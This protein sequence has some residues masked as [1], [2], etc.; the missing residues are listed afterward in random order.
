M[1]LIRIWL[2]NIFKIMYISLYQ[3]NCF[4]SY[5]II[6]KILT[7]Y[8]L[9]CRSTWKRR[10]KKW[11]V[12]LLEFRNWNLN[13]TKKGRSAKGTHNRL[14]TDMFLGKCGHLLLTSI[15]LGPLIFRI[16][17]KIKK[18]VKAHNRYTRIQDELKRQVFIKLF[19]LHFL[20]F[21]DLQKNMLTFLN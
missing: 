20:M 4:V 3:W 13:Y 14:S 2:S 9:I 10:P 11:T 1:L 19:W 7:N 17:S 21:D 16:K 15:F 8:I 12:W 18:F 6:Y 5:K